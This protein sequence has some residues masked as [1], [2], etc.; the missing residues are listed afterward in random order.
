[1]SFQSKLKHELIMTI[2]KD[3]EAKILRYHFVEQW[4]V[5][6]ISTQFGIHYSVV[7]RVLS[8]AGLP[9]IERSV[10]PFINLNS[11]VHSTRYKNPA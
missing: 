1:M 6:T 10:R 7:D 11:A 4:K 2:D 8:Q 3:I 9:K 5:G